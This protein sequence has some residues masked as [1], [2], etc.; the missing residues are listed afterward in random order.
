MDSTPSRTLDFWFDYS[1]P[2]AYIAST[3]VE[4][5][6]RR[7]AATLTFQPMLLGGI[8]RATGTPQNLMNVLGPAKAKHNREDMFRWAALYGID[9]SI[10]AEH[11]QRTVDALRATLAAKCDPKVIAGFYRA[12]W[13]E[14]R[15][16]S[17]EGTMRAVLRAAGHDPDAV[18][19]KANAQDTKDDLKRRTDEAIALGIF[20]APTFIVDKKELFWG[21]DRMHFVSGER[22]EDS[23]PIAGASAG[24]RKL[25]VFWDFSSPFAYL[26][27]TQAKAGAERAGA[28]LSWKPMLL[29]GLFKSIGQVDVP[30][31]SWSAAKQS[32]IAEDMHRW[33]RYWGVP[34]RFPSRFPMSTVKALRAYLALPEERRDAFR[35]R[36]F[37]AYWAEDQDIADDLVLGRLLGPDAAEILLRTQA[38]EI[39]QALIARTEEAKE[40]GVFGAPTWIVNDTEL[41]WGQDRLPLVARALTS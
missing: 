38:P 25:E 16:V 34:F 33:A 5:L 10:P 19:A 32:Y 26:G 29:G 3:Q 18:I 9:L 28:E 21:Q 31:K 1:C 12:Y 15:P 7:M 8:F 35:E 24:R 30:M 23:W 39:K 36:V 40:R 2:Y 37:R 27:C 6:A 17:D 4:S 13:T 14:G 41:F 20:G 11:P 22:C